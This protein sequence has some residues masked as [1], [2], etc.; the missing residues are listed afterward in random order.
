MKSPIIIYLERV[1]NLGAG[2]LISYLVI[3]Y[4]S[5]SDYGVYKYL[6]SFASIFTTFVILG[7]NVTNARY[8]P[9]Y[10]VQKDFRKIN[11]QV[12][13]FFFLQLIVVIL[14]I[15]IIYLLRS[16]DFIKISDKI[17]SIPLL[18]IS[19]LQYL[20]YYLAESILVAFSKRMKLTYLRIILL[21]TQLAIIYVAIF[22][23]SNIVEFIKYVLF[24]SIFETTVLLFGAFS[25]YK[26]V[27]PLF[28]VEKFSLFKQYKYSL[29]N[30]G[31][32]I[33]N[34]LRDN[35][36]TIVA[37]A[38]LFNYN[39][40]SYYSVALIIPNIV[41]G[42][43]PSK[44]FS[45]LILPEFVKK[46]K[47]NGEKGAVFDGLNL[48]AKINIIFLVP[49]VIYAVFMFEFVI[50]KFFGEEY[51][52]NSFH[53]SLFLFLNVIF[54]SYLDLNIMAS[55]IL[56]RS[57]IVFKLNLF[58]VSNIVLLVGLNEYG[59]ISIG[60][61]NVLSTVL[62]VFSFWLV[63]KKHFRKRINFYFVNKEILIYLSVLLVISYL[64]YI[65][66]IYFYLVGFLLISFISAICLVRSEFINTSERE[67]L[68][69]NLPKKIKGYV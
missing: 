43:S 50:G 15:T 23:E 3:N 33:C 25:T 49:A 51:V 27:V 59:A 11:Y 40:V 39:Q 6:L 1:I 69:Q 67:F 34:L 26:K 28:K 65:I 42:F 64:L 13:S 57:D 7:F 30:Y 66:N 58:S 55:N 14:S 17:E 4:F 2:L 60:V 56:E 63:L 18:A 45:G 35:A 46:Y 31:F 16:F 24:F 41:R 10:L 22:M 53:L 68:K 5:S 12:V 36:A 37:V 38:Y 52:V 44:V 32:M 54:L 62:T 8:I 47:K 29:N 19:V 9:E 48:M 61:A 21:F 20:K